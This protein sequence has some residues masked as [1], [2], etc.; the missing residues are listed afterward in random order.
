VQPVL[1][2][3]VR[4]P[5][6]GV[7]C[8]EAGST[9][10]WMAIGGSLVGVSMPGFW[11]GLVL[12]LVFA[13]GLKLLPI[14]GRS[15]VRL[16]SRRRPEETEVNGEPFAA[17]RHADIVGSPTLEPTLLRRTRPGPCRP[18]PCMSVA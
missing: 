11:L 9:W 14:T 17:W 8:G 6:W 15:S 7:V 5:R 16:C 13:M 3:D 12:M 4:H 2:T 10:D 18:R 1:R